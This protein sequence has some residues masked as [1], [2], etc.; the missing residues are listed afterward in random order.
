MITKVQ[1]TNF[2]SHEDSLILLHPGANALLGQ[3]GAG[4]TSILQAIGLCLFNTGTPGTWLRKGC[5]SGRA[6]V[7]FTA[8]DGAEYTVDRKI[9]Q[10]GVRLLDAQGNVLA[11][12]QDDVYTGIRDLL[13]LE[14]NTDLGRL[15]DE[16]IGVPQGD[17]TLAFKSTPGKRRPIFDA[18][19][20]VDEY[21]EAWENLKDV[22]AHAQN[23][24]Q[25]FHDQAT[26]LDGRLEGAETRAKNAQ[27]CASL[28]ATATK[29]L[30]DA[31]KAFDA[32][33]K[34]LE[35]EKAKEQAAVKLQSKS[36]DLQTLRDT[37]DLSAR[38]AE[39]RFG[40]A[41]EAQTWLDG[42]KATID[43]HETD[44]AWLV[45]NDAAVTQAQN[46]AAQANAATHE[47][48][49]IAE[50]IKSAKASLEKA[51]QQVA[52]AP[53]FATLRKALS[54]QQA[55]IPALEQGNEAARKAHDELA[56]RIQAARRNAADL[57]RLEHE[58]AAAHPAGKTSREALAQARA[59]A[60][61]LEQ[62]G[63][64]LDTQFDALAR[65][66]SCPILDVACPA[67]LNGLAV[68]RAERKSTI[69]R[70][71]AELSKAHPALAAQAKAEADAEA[72]YIRVQAN[73]AHLASLR[74]ERDDLA[75]VVGSLPALAA[76]MRDA[77]AGLDGGRSALQATQVELGKEGAFKALAE[78]ATRLAKQVDDDGQLLETCQKR[79]TA[80]ADSK[81][82][83]D[84]LLATK[85]DTKIRVQNRDAFYV[86]AGVKR[87]AA[88]QLEARRK[89]ASDARTKAEQAK[90]AWTQADTDFKAAWT[91][92]AQADRKA[93]DKANLDAAGALAAAKQRL[94]GA[95]ANVTAANALVLEDEAVK[96]SL[97]AVLVELSDANRIRNNV[98]TVRG[99]I[100]GLGPSVA[101]RFVA[102]ISIAADEQFRALNGGR[103]VRLVWRNPD[104][105]HAYE[106]AV[107]GQ[108]GQERLYVDLSGGEQVMAALA[109]RLALLKSLSPVSFAVYDEPT[110][111]LDA[112]ARQNVARA[113]KNSG[114]KQL[115][116]VSHDDSFSASIHNAI[117][118][119]NDGSKTVI[120]DQGVLA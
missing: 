119:D 28:A 9:G 98:T 42:N 19:L 10:S 61:G 75:P 43:G 60:A 92:Q 3:N 70:R 117:H 108:D 21:A 20:R 18:I 111:N 1:L 41:Q 62:V 29:G 116:V 33:A 30:D 94:D 58:A 57:D 82:A 77:K 49:T 81:P 63:N 112:N 84:R 72:A 100:K 105:D 67:D 88:A 96:K 13:G 106:V 83:Q 44:K 55:A 118:L 64:A 23:V 46:D 107:T 12:V 91:P 99:L 71:K 97:D 47:A 38:S 78:S 95:L 22:Q 17:L 48:T 110:I 115:I 65:T 36:R 45:A 26:K 73:A 27:E 85:R 16:L 24:S 25:D 37:A 50:R 14:P 51:N 54:E 76:K 52:A 40:E 7:T 2:K 31:Q 5:K 74:K 39:T 56:I 59:D 89:E 35:A 8:K 68:Q 32:A 6:K 80:M 66:R 53:D 34:H 114:Q 15:Y 109:I 87:A 79:L 113:L 69:E 120:Q 102:Q 101:A 11:E 103:P 86:E 93:A 4:K 104:P 90:A